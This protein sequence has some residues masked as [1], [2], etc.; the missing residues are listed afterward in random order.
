MPSAFAFSTASKA[1]P[2]ESAPTSRAMTGD[3]VRSPPNLQLIDRRGAEGVARRHH[4][5]VAFGLEALRQLADGRRLPRAVDADDQHHMRLQIGAHG[6]R[7]FGF[8]ENARYFDG[9]HFANFFAACAFLDAR[10]AERLGQPR[11]RR[12]TEGPM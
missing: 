12:K 9:E 3:P 1:R 5:A 8:D 7:C 2:A 11:G 10:L 6:E 4:H